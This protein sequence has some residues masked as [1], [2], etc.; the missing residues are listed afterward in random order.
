[1]KKIILASSLAAFAFST[2][3]LQ[4]AALMSLQI[5]SRTK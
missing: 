3:V 1:M 2:N 5:P 4:K